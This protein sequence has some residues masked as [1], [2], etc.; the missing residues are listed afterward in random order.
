MKPASHKGMGEIG[1]PAGPPSAASF[2][3]QSLDNAMRY[4]RDVSQSSAES[5]L[6]LFA[7]A[8]NQAL[9]RQIEVA[10]DFGSFVRTQAK[11][12]AQVGERVLPAGPMREAV[13]L[14]AKMQTNV[15]DTVV[16]VATQWGRRFGHLAFAFPVT[17]RGV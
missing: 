10:H 1:G 8:S 3:S 9:I 11:E 15:A 13:A 12:F 4:S 14:T 6:A 2:P 7:F 5:V 17:H 16:A